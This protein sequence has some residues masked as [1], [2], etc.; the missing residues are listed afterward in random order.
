MKLSK[1][2]LRKDLEEL[3]KP[4][5]DNIMLLKTPEF[6]QVFD[7]NHKGE[8]VQAQFHSDGK[9]LTVYIMYWYGK[10]PAF[11]LTPERL[12]TTF[13][14]GPE[15]MAKEFVKINEHLVTMAYKQKPTLH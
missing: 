8:S 1:K 12:E 6:K 7:F 10:A 14:M 13:A 9:V 2:E 3:V 11:K 15:W 5:M 4:V